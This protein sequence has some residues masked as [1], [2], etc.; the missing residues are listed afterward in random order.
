MLSQQLRQRLFGS[1]E[2]RSDR[3]RRLSR[4][5]LLV[6]SSLIAGSVAFSFVRLRGRISEYFDQRT[7]QLVSATDAQLDLINSEYQ[8]L[9]SADL[10][11]AFLALT[12]NTATSKSIDFEARKSLLGYFDDFDAGRRKKVDDLL[13]ILK[14]DMGAE[15]SVFA[16]KDGRFLRVATT[17]RSQDGASMEGSFLETSGDVAKSLLRGETFFGVDDLLGELYIAKAEPI[18]RLDGEIVGAISVG[19]PVRRLS[20]IGKIIRSSSVG[21]F[22]FL[23]L[24]DQQGDVIYVTEGQDVQQVQSLVDSV[25]SVSSQGVIETTTVDRYKIRSYMFEP[26]RFE[27]YV[28]SNIDEIN[29]VTARIVAESMLPIVL[30]LIS[31]MILTV[32]LERQLKS[33]LLE[34]ER[35]RVAAEEQSERAHKA[36]KSAFLASRA[37]SAFLAN[38][39]HELRTPMNAIIGYSEMLIEDSED[40]EPADFVADLEKI[41]SSGKHLLGLINGVLDLSK[42]EAG[43]MTL[44]VENVSLRDLFE[45]VRATAEPLAQ[46]NKNQFICEKPSY[47]EDLIRSDSTKI[48]QSLINLI[49]NACK[50]TENGTVSLSCQVER[51]DHDFSWVSFR[52]SDT[53]IGMSEDQLGKLFKDFSQADASTTRQYGGTGLG[54]SLS[55]KLTRL[56]G[57]DITVE[58]SLGKG[59]TFTMKIPRYPTAE[60]SA[61]L[62]PDG[63]VNSGVEMQVVDR[64]GRVLVVDDDDHSLEM[65]KHFLL[66]ASF[67]VLNAPNSEAGLEQAR[68]S[69][70]DILIVDIHAS[71]VSGWDMLA[72]IRAD[73]KLKTLP[74]IVV[75]RD[76]AKELSMMLGAAG[77]LQAPIDW[78]RLQHILEKLRANRDLTAQADVAL[79]EASPHLKSLVETMLEEHHW[80]LRSYS[81]SEQ[82]L[83]GIS[84]DL[85]HLLIVDLSCDPAAV[86]EAIEEIRVKFDPKTLPLVAMSENPLEAEI[87]QRIETVGSRWF[88]FSG[89]NVDMLVSSVEELMALSSEENQ[90]Q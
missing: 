7:E 63:P 21:K 57:G 30:V 88:T 35:L 5:W 64:R 73:E 12:G 18:Q 77:A 79:L 36:K 59:S 42:I 68:T 13:G 60:L 90:K 9:T 28:A 24:V 54:L 17:L 44:Y 34:A 23:A 20:E 3:V 53:G 16:L 26:W 62:N 8:D 48:R 46:K 1:A 27:I 67:D 61:Q 84:T 81:S 80:N 52:V 47:A 38:M 40:L 31:V 89:S 49:G 87:L 2:S 58:S 29:S 66:K 69:N 39:S 72:K 65:I 50:F 85:P 37:K 55:R 15:A 74:V 45:E 11:L 33:T 43:K 71:Q 10:S 82:L 51:D 70:P 75:S 86:M 6:V 19:Y 56:M 83:S 32:L 76:D 22:G 25:A 41:L 14:Q 78:S 4:A